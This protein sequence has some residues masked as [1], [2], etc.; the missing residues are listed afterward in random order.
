MCSVGISN[1]LL[2]GFLEKKNLKRRPRFSENAKKKSS[3]ALGAT[4]SPVAVEGALSTADLVTNG[5][6]YK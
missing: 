1:R 6:I 4:R 3:I 2:D 5:T